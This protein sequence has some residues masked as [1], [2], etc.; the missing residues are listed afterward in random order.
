M[1]TKEEKTK[2]TSYKE[3]KSLQ[4]DKG[5]QPKKQNKTKSRGSKRRNIDETI[6]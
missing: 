2:P 1:E 3:T 4:G 5:S 6:Q